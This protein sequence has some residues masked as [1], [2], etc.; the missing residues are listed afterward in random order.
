[1]LSLGSLQS[2]NVQM[3]VGG[4]VQELH[5]VTGGN[6]QGGFIDLSS[7]VISFFFFSSIHKNGSLKMFL[8]TSRIVHSGLIHLKWF[9]NSFSTF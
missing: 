7:S 4:N 5:L 9:K 1:M 8:V 3:I 2:M 6:V